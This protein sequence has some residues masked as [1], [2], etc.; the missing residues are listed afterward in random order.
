MSPRPSR[1][2]LLVET[3]FVW[4]KRS[5]CS[6]LHVGAVIHRDGRILVQGYNGAPAGLDHCDHTCNCGELGHISTVSHDVWCNSQPHACRAVHAEANA[7]AYAARWGVGL[8]GA[9]IVVTD[10]PCL[11][12][13]RLIVNAGIAFVVYVRPYRLQDGVQLLQEAGIP[14]EQYLDWEEPRLVGSS[15]EDI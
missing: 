3:A 14:V 1:E 6:R 15:G 8:E 2:E 7:I 9:Q 10:Q 13:A 12:C 11:N 4:A 5:T